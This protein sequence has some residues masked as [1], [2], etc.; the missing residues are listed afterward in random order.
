MEF[1]EA[2]LKA[3]SFLKEAESKGYFLC[4]VFSSSTTSVFAEWIFHLSGKEKALDCCVKG[5]AIQVDEAHSIGVPEK[6]DM[7]KVKITAAKALESLISKHKNPLT[8]LVSLHG[9]PPVWTINFISAAM[10]ATAYDI[11]AETGEMKREETTS[12]LRKD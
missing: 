12:I 3:G 5:D 2:L 4:S 7:E 11:S 10:T 1:D 6:L 9:S 8:I